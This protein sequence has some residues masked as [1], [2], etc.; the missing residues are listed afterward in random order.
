MK[1]TSS[2]VISTGIVALLHTYNGMANFTIVASRDI[3]PTSAHASQ[4]CNYVSDEMENLLL[5]IGHQKPKTDF[6]IREVKV[7]ID[8]T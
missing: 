4:L 8:H 1:N 2:Y 7:Q 5:D 3:C 6:Q